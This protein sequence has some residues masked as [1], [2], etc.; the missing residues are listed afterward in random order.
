MDYNQI[1]LLLDKYWEGETSLEEEVQLRAYFAQDNIPEDLKPLQPLFA[2]FAAEQ[3]LELD[4]DFERKL[5][6][7]LEEPA[8]PRIAPR[9]RLYQWGARAA[10]LA[11]LVVAA[12]YLFQQPIE[13]AD[14]QAVDW[15]SHEAQTPEQAWEQTKAALMLVSRKLNKGAGEAAK[16]VAK[17]ETATKIIKN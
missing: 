12:F 10:A 9:L 1:K 16:G 4:E 6:T 2:F 8:P 14:Q 5:L 15:S 13:S 7:Q 17:M 11:L 3:Q